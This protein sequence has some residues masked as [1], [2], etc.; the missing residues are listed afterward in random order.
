MFVDELKIAF[1][2]RLAQ[3]DHNIR[4]LERKT[5]VNYSTLNRLHSQKAGFGN[6]PALTVQRLFP[7]MKVF[8]FR[9]DYPSGLGVSVI[10]AN[11]APIA[12]GA[13]AKATVRYGKN[14]VV[15]TETPVPVPVSAAPD[16]AIDRDALELQI[17]ESDYLT[18]EEQKKFLI[19]LKKEI[20]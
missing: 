20:K 2:R 6:L 18:A 7:E 14:A 15:N 8:F 4:S 5:Q 17:L 9:E 11:H 19:F 1:E 10:G 13:H 12:N 16:R 3:E